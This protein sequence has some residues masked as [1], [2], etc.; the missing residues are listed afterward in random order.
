MTGLRM[1]LWA[2]GVICFASS[3]APAQRLWYVA[4]DA[5]GPTHDGQSWATAF[6]DLNAALEVSVEEDTIRVAQGTYTPDPTGLVHPREATF[7]LSPGVIVLGGYPGSRA[8]N[9]DDRDP[10][11]YETILSGDLN[12]DDHSGGDKSDN[13][14]HVLTALI[15]VVGPTLNG[16][17][18]TGGNANG[19]GFPT[20]HGV[21]GG[22]RSSGP[23]SVVNCLL[24]GNTARYGGGMFNLEGSPIITDCVFRDNAATYGAALMFY[25]YEDERPTSQL[26]GGGP[27]HGIPR[28]TN[29]LFTRNH[30]TDTAGALWVSGV[31]ED[32]TLVNCVFT[33]N[34]ADNDAGAVMASGGLH[35]FENCLLARNEASRNGGA[36]WTDGIVSFT[37][38]TITWNRAAIGGGVF[39]PGAGPSL[40]N[41]IL[42]GNRDNAGVGE[43]AQ[44]GS[45]FP[46]LASHCCVQ[47]WTGSWAGEQSFR[48]DPAFVP[49][50]LGDYYLSQIAAGQAADSPC[51]DAGNT[52]VEVLA[53]ETMTTRCDEA[54]DVGTVDV[55]YHFPATGTRLVMADYD[56]DGDVD[57]LD[58]ARFQACFSGNTEEVPPWCRI[59]DFQLDGDVDLGD[60]YEHSQA[61]TGP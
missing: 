53:L 39:S 6:A 41:T 47:G 29:C 26:K 17:T 44:V 9:P 7:N 37:N 4:L 51:I 5:P 16:F 59:F 34:S 31:Q 27:R 24:Q 36:L 1:A 58:S 20:G 18:I 35:A 55:G 48:T 52:A 33:H 38:C 45:R 46:P 22:L 23:L 3:G 60:V 50:P 56:R 2:S 10:R 61:M 14:Y 15:G 54:Y 40:T 57:L 25:G 13:S 12:R 28:V 43:S 19:V 11:R 30:A 21:G 8:V 42:W 32:P 49:G